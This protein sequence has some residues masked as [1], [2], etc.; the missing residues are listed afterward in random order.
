MVFGGRYFFTLLP[1]SQK[2]KQQRQYY[3]APQEELPRQ[4]RIFDDL[5]VGLW[6]IN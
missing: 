1:K 2:T 3:S 6:T 4:H 5:I